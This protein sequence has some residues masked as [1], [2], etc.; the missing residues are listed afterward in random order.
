MRAI[1]T[2]CL[3]GGITRSFCLRSGEC[4]QI[5]VSLRS[6]L[7]RKGSSPRAEDKSD[8]SFEARTG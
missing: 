6:S 2:Y 5:G 4:G 1:I 3:P 7:V 8:V